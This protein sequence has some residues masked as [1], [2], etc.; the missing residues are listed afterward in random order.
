MTWRDARSTYPCRWLLIE[1]LEAR[2]AEG[3][4]VV[5]DLAV[6]EACADAADALRQ[7]LALH[8]AAPGRELYVA[9]TDRSQLEIE[10]QEWLG[11]RRVA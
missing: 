4:R 5:E 7:Y 1:A 6:V 8:R 10:E 9:H 11:P 3:R 2:S